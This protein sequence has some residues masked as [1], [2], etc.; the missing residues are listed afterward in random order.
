MNTIIMNTLTGAV[1]EYA[2]FDFHAITPTHAGSAVG[3]YALGGDL[4][5]APAIDAVAITGDTQWGSSLRKRMD[6]VFYGLPATTGE[7]TCVVQGS[8]NTYEYDFTI[9]PEGESR[10]M[11][12]KGISENY[13]AFGF[14]NVAGSNFVLDKIE[15][16]VVQSTTRRT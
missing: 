16:N 7:G 8:S 3:L 2:G 6:G 9:R 15:V 11:P 5:V 13:L 10:A 14:K 12:G 1:S 4:D